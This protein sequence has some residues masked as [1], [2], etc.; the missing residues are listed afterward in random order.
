MHTN[1][2]QI[3]FNSAV[4][5]R[6]AE[7]YGHSSEEIK[8]Y[9]GVSEKVIQKIW[10]GSRVPTYNQLT[11]LADLYNIRAS[12]FLREGLPNFEPRAL[13]FRAK[14]GPNYK[15]NPVALSKFNLTELSSEIIEF[16]MEEIGLGSLQN[17]LSKFLTGQD[18]QLSK[19][20]FAKEIRQ[21]LGYSPKKVATLTSANKRSFAEF[22]LRFLLEQ[23]GINIRFSKV[24]LDHFTGLIF[25]NSTV[26]TVLVSTAKHK[27]SYPFTICH[28]IAHL[29]ADHGSGVSESFSNTKLERECDRFAANFLAPNYLVGELLSGIKA[30]NAKVDKLFRNTL[31]S[32]HAAAYRLFRMEEISSS[33]YSHYKGFKP[34]K[35]SNGYNQNNYHQIQGDTFKKLNKAGILAPLICSKA[36]AENVLSKS[37]VERALGYSSNLLPEVKRLISQRIA[38]L[39]NYDAPLSIREEVRELLK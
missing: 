4:L 6:A 13:N 36:L 38:D 20:K 1:Q 35:G 15:V 9:L 2:E 22:Y 17:G 21:F 5:Q 3:E 26:S 8:E 24:N 29:L 18:I 34:P 27:N 25:H 23:H 33:T 11:R 30:E 39:E 7:I 16:A 10:A 12:H 37:D 19:V 14:S 28:E 32:R 31:L